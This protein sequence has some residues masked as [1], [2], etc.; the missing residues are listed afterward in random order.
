MTGALAE[1]TIIFALVGTN[2]ILAASE[3]AVVASRKARLRMEAEA[4]HQGA[5]VALE[6]ANAPGRF[7]STVQIGITA[8]AVIAGAFGGA[9]VAGTLAPGLSTL[10]VP[11]AMAAQVAVVVVIGAVT[12]LTVIVGELV[13]KR[14]AL[15]DPERLASRVA[16]PMHILSVAATPLVRLLEKSSDGV[17]RGLGFKE[18]SETE[19]TEDEIRGMIAHAVERGELEA[20]EQQITERLF[21]LSDT[22]VGSLATPRDSIVWL[23]AAAGIDEWRRALGEVRHT[24]YVVARGSL[25]DVK[26]YVKV[27]D[28]LR[29]MLEG[30]SLVLDPLLR[31]PHFLPDWTPAFRLLELFQWSGDHMAFITGRNGKVVGLVTL[32]DVLEGIVGDLPEPEEIPEP[33]VLERAD[34]S[35][36][37]DGLLPFDQFL[38]RF[39]R[40]G[41]APSRWPTVHAFMVEQLDGSP[42]PAASV[43]WLGL[44][45]EVMDMDGS[46]VDKILVTRP[47]EATEWDGNH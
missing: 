33:A 2:G 16:R 13:P 25:D 6:L 39:D 21:R 8:M 44:R 40:E 14:I 17:L 11:P 43:E 15:H 35:W 7:L 34:G 32:N 41:A 46:R 26:G 28:L 23:D 38:H 3:I 27:Q 12:L 30:R 4:G 29:E 47:S 42:R 22:R 20:T 36:L 19:V 31:R 10:G 9:R 18:G 45:L 5:R 24:R 1:V 37:V